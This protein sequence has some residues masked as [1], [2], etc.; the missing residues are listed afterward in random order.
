MKTKSLALGAFVVVATLFPLQQA[1]AQ[2]CDTDMTFMYAGMTQNEVFKDFTQTRNCGF[3]GTPQNVTCLPAGT[4]QVAVMFVAA[5]APVGLMSPSCQ[6]SCAAVTTGTV[7]P[8]CSITIDGSD[9][10]PVELLDFSVE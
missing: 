7:K 9:G 10:L 8:S 6:W 3:T 5:Y 1:D 2:T 4:A